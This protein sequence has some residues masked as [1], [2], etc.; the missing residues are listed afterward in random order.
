VIDTATNTVI[1]TIDVGVT[2]WGVA[3]GPDG[4]RVYVTDFGGAVSVITLGEGDA[5]LV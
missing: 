4:T 5:M 2:P 3:I 1:A